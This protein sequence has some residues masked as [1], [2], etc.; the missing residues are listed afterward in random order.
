MRLAHLATECIPPKVSCAPVTTRTRDTSHLAR[1][2]LAS[3]P[4]P[5]ST[6]SGLIPIDRYNV[7]GDRKRD[8][9]HPF[10]NAHFALVQLML[11]HLCPAVSH[12]QPPSARGH[13]GQR[14]APN[15]SH[16]PRGGGSSHTDDDGGGGVIRPSPVE[17]G[18]AKQTFAAWAVLRFNVVFG[19]EILSR[20]QLNF[21][22][23]HPT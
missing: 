19:T 20:R 6:P 15:A 23:Q 11:N 4:P 1:P 12:D 10:F 17:E 18:G 3:P 2:P 13:H 5:A 14:D 16:A 8:N 7:W 22:Y 9:V 21:S